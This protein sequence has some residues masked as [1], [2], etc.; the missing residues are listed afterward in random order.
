MPPHDDDEQLDARR[1]LAPQAHGRD[2]SSLVLLFATVAFLVWYVPLIP[3]RIFDADE[4]EHAHAAW[5][6]FK[7][8]VPY[9]DFFEHHTPWYYV[10]L[11]PLFRWFEVDASF[12]SARHFLLLARVLSFA[13]TVLSVFLVT[14]I[15]R[16]WEGRQGTQG[17]SKVGALAGLLLVG[18]PFFL[19]KAIE[20]RPDLLALPFF[21]GALC[22]LLRGLETG[23]DSPSRR[24]WSF[25]GGGLSLGAAIMCTQKMLFVLP[26]LFA[27][28]GVWALSARRHARTLLVGA[29]VL[30]M[31]VPGVLTWAAFARLHAGG[32]FIAN[33]FL[34]NSRWKHVETNLLHP[35][36]K[37]TRLILILSLLG[38]LG[39]LR[40]FFGSRKRSYAEV[41]LL[42]TLLGLCAGVGII[43]AAQKQYYLMPLPLICLFAAAGLFWL[44]DWLGNRRRAFQAAR[45]WLLALAV[46]VLFKVP[47][48]A[49]RVSYRERNDLQLARLRYVFETTKPTDLVMDGWEGT[50]VFRPHAFYYYFIHEELLP[51]LPV[52]RVDAYV[53]DLES[54]KIRPKMIALDA[55]LVGLD[56]RFLRFVLNRYASRDGVLYFRRD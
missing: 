28:L 21:L 26:G 49:L 35:F 19:Q 41:V 33:N 32:E 52:D 23:T 55:N 10:V 2:R 7:G 31:L 38:L 43:P 27:G 40:R 48:K 18:Q 9:K 51:M 29:F 25:V 4:F 8:M 16:F 42:C 46:V 34:L 36:I 6:W 37:S 22:C 56:P 13:L 5:C 3:R 12:E 14:R 1:A 53:D 24:L 15:G 44:V 11:R 17:Q 50:G 47:V 20:M 45:P 39:S 30:G 54:G